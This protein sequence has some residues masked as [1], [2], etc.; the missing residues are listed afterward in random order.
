MTLSENIQRLSNGI[1]PVVIAGR[2]TE[3][4]LKTNEIVVDRW[5]KGTAV[6]SGDRIPYLAHALGTD[7]NGLYEGVL[8]TSKA[9][10]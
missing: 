3:A 1:D 5:I 10:A 4:G 8:E 2:M 9:I 7:P 6:P